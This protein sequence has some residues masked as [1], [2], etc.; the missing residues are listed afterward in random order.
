M[1][2]FPLLTLLDRILLKS[3]ASANNLK[4]VTASDWNKLSKLKRH[5]GVTQSM[6][7]NHSN[8]LRVTTF[9]LLMSKLPHRNKEQV[10]CNQFCYQ[11]ENGF[12]RAKD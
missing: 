4:K 7:I 12:I 10:H 2:H 11:V 8:W 1:N 6:M 3:K 9:W 5:A